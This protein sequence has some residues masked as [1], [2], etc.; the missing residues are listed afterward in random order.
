MDPNV[1]QDCSKLGS[2]RRV[3]DKKEKRPTWEKIVGGWQIE[4]ENDWPW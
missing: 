1:T 3:K 2:S 4:N